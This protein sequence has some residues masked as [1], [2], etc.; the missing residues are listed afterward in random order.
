M[1]D[2]CGHP[3]V[4]WFIFPCSLIGAVTNISISIINRLWAILS[5][6]SCISSLCGIVLKYFLISISTTALFQ[7]LNVGWFSAF[8][9]PWQLSPAR[10][11]KELGR[12]SG[13]YILLRMVLTVSCTN[14]SS[15]QDTASGRLSPSSFGISV[16]F[17]G[18]AWYV[19]L[20][21]RL[22]RWQIFVSKFS[23]RL[24]LSADQLQ[25]L[26]SHPVFGTVLLACRHLWC[27]QD[28]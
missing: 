11:P 23:P 12:K 14:L 24:A 16:I 21:N 17:A 28:C 8:I 20:R 5:L 25:S 2:P 15:K 10:K 1:I 13:S 9:A 22:M 3:R 27:G 4:F 19:P 7:F 18:L 6:R 26:S